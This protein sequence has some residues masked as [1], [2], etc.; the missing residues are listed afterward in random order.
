M[1]VSSR[2]IPAFLVAALL[3]PTFLE[4]ETPVD[5]S[6]QA[7]SDGAVEINVLAG[8]LTITGW[9]ED[10]ISVTGT[11]GDEIEELVVECGAG[12]SEIRAEIVRHEGRTTISNSKTR[13]EIHIPSRS[14]V[15]VE[16]VSAS[17]SADRLRGAASVGTVSG[18]V[19]VHGAPASLEVETVSG[20]IHVAEAVSPLSAET[21][22]GKIVLDTVTGRTHAASVSSE[23]KILGG[24]V[25][26]GSFESVSG[27]VDFQGGVAG[28]GR[29]QAESH[30]G[31]VT[32]RL[33]TSVSAD[34]RASSFS[35]SISNRLAG[36][37]NPTKSGVGGGDELRQTLGGG[38]ARIEVETFSGKI[39]LVNG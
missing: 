1:N 17:V 28:S 24:E 7:S 12:R 8:Q 19:E 18:D 16:T 36:G 37:E 5:K 26:E 14:A 39:L 31:N 25:E 38:T 4:A 32:L 23:V 13:L 2:R 35:G 3:I 15:E 27:D 30:S 6:C 34:L 21:V 22:S 11:A 29:L 10:R 9:D 33:P 20:K